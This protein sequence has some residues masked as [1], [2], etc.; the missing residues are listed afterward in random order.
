MIR[1]VISVY[2]RFE[3]VLLVSMFSG[4][5]IVIFYQVIMR[6]VFNNSSVWSEELGKF[7]FVWITWLG[8][9]LGARKGEHLTVTILLDKLPFNAKHLTSIAAQ[10]VVI[11]VSA[12]TAWYSYT[13]V[14]SQNHVPFA[15]IR[16]SMSWGYLAVLVG[17]VLMCLRCIHDVNVSYRALR[18]GPKE[19]ENEYEYEEEEEVEE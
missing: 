11:G 12:I 10:L 18:E 14:L 13:L 7:L 3:N 8:I 15:A 9:S 5:V 4:M 19:I 17:C 16:I 6:Y 1:R 2:D